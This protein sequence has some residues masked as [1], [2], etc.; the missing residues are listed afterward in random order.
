MQATDIMI[1]NVISVEAGT[2]IENIASCLLKHRISAVPV[3]DESKQVIGTVREG[4]LMRRPEIETDNGHFW[5]LAELLSTRDRAADYIKAHG[6]KASDVM[7]RA[8]ISVGD[9]TPVYEI[10]ELLEKHHIK[11]V[12]V[13]RD[14][15]LVGIV[16]RANL[17]HALAAREARS[18]EIRT[19]D[20]KDIREDLMREIP[21][22]AGIDAP[23]INAVVT[24]GVV[25]LYG[26]VDTAHTKQAVQVAA[27]NIAGIKSIENN[28]GSVPPWM[29]ST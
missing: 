22:V 7:S 1:A 17:L 12:Q 18:I 13:V 9:D 19:P 28:L 5:W 25:Q 2:T 6:R 27:E 29:F 4:D 23:L 8:M 20:D 11:K 15:K 16:S 3:V 10:A 26:I 21:V 24:D 14:R